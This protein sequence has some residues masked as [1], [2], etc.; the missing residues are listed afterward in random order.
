MQQPKKK[1]KIWRRI[2]LLLIIFGIYIFTKKI[3]LDAK[4]TIESGE[5][6]AKIFNELST[7]EK[8]RM[9]LYIKTHNIDFSKLEAGSYT[10][11]GTYNKTEFVANILKGSEKDYLRLT[12]LEG[13]SIYDI[14]EA[15]ARKWYITGGDFVKYVTNTNNI[16]QLQTS[17]KFLENSALWIL[18]SELKTLEGFLYP[19]TYN[20][21]KNKPLIP[22]LV[23]K[24]LQT[25]QSRVRS[26]VSEPTDFYKTMILASVVEKEERNNDNKATVAGIFLKRLEIWMKIDADITLCYGL[27]TSYTS[28]TPAVIGRNVNDANNTYNTRA[29]RWLPPT[30]ICNPT[31]ESINAVINPQTS[32]YLY[33]LHDMEGNIH[34]GSSLEEHNTN[35]NKYLN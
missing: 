8:I 26:K 14:D 6:T 32:D 21:D 3:T 27:K 18:N 28:C 19:D 29:V 1:L 33:Y 2:L 5:S 9:K 35:K 20:V 16:T 24:Q 22:Q 15:L 25:F 11:S 17:Y 30:T 7:I 10:F 13:R 34:Y 31:R 23:S 4:I 12:I